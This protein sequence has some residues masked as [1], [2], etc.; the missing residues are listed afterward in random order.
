MSQMAHYKSLN[1]IIQHNWKDVA[2]SA[3][4]LMWRSS[5]HSACYVSIV[6]LS[7]A[8]VGTAWSLLRSTRN[9][10]AALYLF[11]KHFFGVIVPGSVRAVIASYSL[12]VELYANRIMKSGHHFLM[13]TCAWNDRGKRGRIF[14]AKGRNLNPE[15]RQYNMFRNTSFIFNTI[16]YVLHDER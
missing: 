12:P 11:Q 8:A 5:D 15:L 9:G 14:A 4:D 10:Q 1:R 13:S 16:F 2:A 6:A 3:R 7:T